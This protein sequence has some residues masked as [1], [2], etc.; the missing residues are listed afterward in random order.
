MATMKI[1][2]MGGRVQ[3]CQVVGLFSGV[4]LE[5]AE[6]FV[7]GTTN[8]TPEYLAMNPNGK[9]PVLETAEG[10]IYESNAIC[11]YLARL[12]WFRPSGA[13]SLY[14]G[15]VYEQGLI[16]QWIDNIVSEAEPVAP[17]LL[18]PVLGY[19]EKNPAAEP[20]AKAQLQKFLANLESHLKS[21]EWLV[22]GRCTLAD[23]VIAASLTGMYTHVL[24]PTE[25]TNA[26]PSVL[27]WLETIYAMPQ[28]MAVY[29]RQTQCGVVPI[30]W[31]AKRVRDTFV[32]YFVEQ[33]QHQNVVSS[34]VVPHEDP[35]LLFANAGMNQFK[36]IFLGKADP[37]SALAKM[38][39]ACNSQKCIRA[40]GKH[41]DLDDVGKDTYHHTFFEMLGNWSFG[42]YFKREAITWAFE[43]LTKVYGLNSDRLYATYFMGDDQTPCDDEAKAIWEEFLPAWRVL[44][45]DGKDNFWEMG[46]VGPCGPCTEIHY[47]RIGDR[48][49]SALVN[50]DDPNVIEIWNVVF[51]QFNREAD[52]SLRTLPAQHVDTGMGF[53]RITSILQEKTSNY[54]TDIFT[55]IFDAIQDLTKCRSYT[56][57][58]GD[59][60]ED[61]V[62]TAY[63]VIADHIR[64]LS[65][66]IADG[67]QPGNDGRNYVLRRIL[68]RAV[69]FGSEKLG[70]PKGYFNK[71]VPTVAA[72]MGDVFPE[73]RA[74]AADIQAILLEEETSFG[75]TLDKGIARF[76]KAAKAA[77]SEGSKVVDG[78]VAF[79]LW[80]TY[81][82]P[83]DLTEIMAED[84][85][86]TVDMERYKKCM[87]QQVENSRASQKKGGAVELKMEAE[88]TANIAKMGIS[89]TDDKAKFVWNKPLSSTCK[90]IMTPTGFVQTTAGLEEGSAVGLV[91]DATAF[92]AEQGGQVFD[93]GALKCPAGV[94]DVTG[95]QVAAGF[96][97]HIGPMP[98][99]LTLKVGDKVTGEVNYER[100]RLI[101]PNHT[102]THVLN[103]ALREVLGGDINQRGS[104]VD[105]EKLRFDFSHK[106]QVD[107]NSLEKVENLV[108]KAITDKLEVHSKEASLEAAKS[109]NGL[110]AVFGEVYPDPVRVVAVGASID[111]ILSNPSKDDW[112]KLSVEFCG[113]TH[114]SNTSEAGQFALLVE[115]G[116]AKGI[117]RI[118]GVTGNAAKTAIALAD[119]LASKVK[120][121]DKL[122][123]AA[124][125]SE[126]QALK[127][128][129]D[130]AVIPSVRKQQLRDGVSK[131]VK[132][133]M[134]AN[135]KAAGASKQQIVAEAKAAA[136]KAAGAGEK[137]C[138]VFVDV[139]ADMNGMKEA[140]TAIVKEGKVAIALYCVDS[141]KNKLICYTGVPPSVSIDCVGW[142]KAALAPVGGKGG[143]G[144]GGMAQGQGAGG[145]DQVE[146]A[147]AAGLAFAKA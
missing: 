52:G 34:S 138:Q 13:I 85:G 23:V 64:T 41:N 21:R 12:N 22:G 126:A 51:M 65:F 89:P 49:A 134:D 37:N 26:C 86:M 71:L 54:D 104:L 87:E 63:R 61:G 128:S 3:K 147:M 143:G 73:V 114:I 44:P 2:G 59:E 28:F 31:P 97:L 48:D 74:K 33:R 35:T 16:D 127:Q 84:A 92:Y 101:A 36:P 103:F 129:I 105:E 30:S 88:A 6:N 123:G 39:R 91:L 20:G 78:D 68:R 79:Q 1:W 15:T 24:T 43:L 94:F 146:A 25:Y 131:L 76:Q 72:L 4:N 42:D 102:M 108:N 67:A 70:A 7:P 145:K 120:A 69:R 122:S 139:P 45:F 109:I 110:R 112:A 75:K 40:G 132:K 99:G 142:M 77:Q 137:Y 141:A 95:V 100:R 62:D 111:N 38:K 130:N 90:A 140:V 125:E 14:A 57:K 119:D 144:K 19:M 98:S 46:D 82:F 27:K 116:I 66:A 8:K 124:L 115:E 47:D 9:F 135:K 10:P 121:A 93:T 83:V 50:Y 133:V 107:V 11:R 53:E 56:G 118:I 113:G 136:T 55:P 29:K 58:V 17:V 96:V 80:D 106:S 32:N 117:R 81:G 18:Y 5:V 60:D